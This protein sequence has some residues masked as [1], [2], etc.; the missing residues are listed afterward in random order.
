MSSLG[1][2]PP[3][4]KLIAQTFKENQ[5]QIDDYLASVQGLHAFADS[6]RWD[7][8]KRELLPGS[9]YSIPR[10]MTVVRDHG[11]HNVTPDCVVQRDQ[12]YGLVVEMKKHYRDSEDTE[13]FEQLA[14]Y[15]ED[16][17]GWWTEDERIPTHDLVLLTHYLSSTRARDAYLLW[18]NRGKSF[19]RPFAIV[20]FNRAAQASAFYTLKRVEGQLSDS[21][22]NEALRQG[23]PIPEGI[24]LD[25]IMRFKFYDG[26]P[27]LIHTM[28]LIHDYILPSLISPDGFDPA[29]GKPTV[30]V[31]VDGV[32]SKLHEQFCGPQAENRHPML[33]RKVWVEKALDELAAVGLAKV[34]SKEGERHYRFQLRRPRKRDTI[35]YLTG[36]M[37]RKQVAGGQVETLGVEGRAQVQGSLFEDSPGP[38]AG[39]DADTNRDR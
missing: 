31:T 10:T 28:H 30:E 1:P 21:Q 37:V 9:R 16:L 4:E 7:D 23:K 20:E 26:P 25:Y 5:V 15:D 35:E 24:V 6:A 38:S 33:P 32:A 39:E 3:L 2:K 19:G 12:K 14:T 17:L 18:V 22:H 29:R 13:A 36:R 27:P 11:L 34:T 8:G